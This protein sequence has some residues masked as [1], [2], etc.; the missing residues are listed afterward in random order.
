M[1]PF[2]LGGTSVPGWNHCRFGIHSC[3][4][5]PEAIVIFLFLLEGIQLLFGSV[6]GKKYVIAAWH[7]EILLRFKTCMDK[8]GALIIDLYYKRYGRQRQLNVWI[9]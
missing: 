7:D 6:L 5:F 8:A 2:L 3:L 9:V 4:D 1:R